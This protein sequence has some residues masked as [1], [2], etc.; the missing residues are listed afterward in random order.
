[1]TGKCEAIFDF[2]GSGVDELSFKQGEILHITGELNGWFIGKSSD[3][4][5]TGIFPANHVT[6]LT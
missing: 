3:S 6:L 5:R 2:V 1:M 4:K